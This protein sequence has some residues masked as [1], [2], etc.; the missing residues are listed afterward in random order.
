MPSL[1]RTWWIVGGGIGETGDRDQEIITRAAAEL[2][3]VPGVWSGSG[4]GFPHGTS[5]KSE[6]HGTGR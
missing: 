4:I 6:H 2:G 1:P 5:Q 3:A